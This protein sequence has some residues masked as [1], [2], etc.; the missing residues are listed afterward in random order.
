MK[1]EIVRAIRWLVAV[2][3]LLVVTCVWIAKLNVRGE[4]VIAPEPQAP[5]A[6]LATIERGA[7]LARAG[8]CGGCH[9]APGAAAFAGGLGIETSFGTLFT[10]NITPDAETGIGNWSAAEFWRAM[11]HGRSKDGR[12]LYPAFPYPNFTQVTRE[13]SDALYAWLRSIPSVQQAN[14]P[15][16]LGFPYN[17]QAALAVWR[18]LYFKPAEF[19]ADA[20]Q[21]AEWNRGR[22]RRRARTLRGLPLRAQPARGDDPGQGL[23]GRRDAGL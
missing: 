14:R 16:A 23:H 5:P 4:A 7:Y 22:Y 1:P 9:T 6:S 15:H 20:G 21:S 8:N 18:A 17:T 11:H 10:S 12:L 3:A 19:G 2:L 13:D